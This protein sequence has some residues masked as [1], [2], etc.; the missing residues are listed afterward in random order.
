MAQKQR[1]NWE[2]NE[3]IKK[4]MEARRFVLRNRFENDEFEIGETIHFIG[5]AIDQLN[6]MKLEYVPKH[7]H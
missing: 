7:K 1:L 2:L 6:I 4:L 3:V 5:R